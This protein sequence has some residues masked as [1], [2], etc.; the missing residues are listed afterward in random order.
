MADPVSWKVVEKGWKVVA[1]DGEELGS[2][3][4]V[5]GDANA[6]I[7]N[8][9]NVSPGV[10]RHS[11][12]VPAERVAAIWEGR[13]ELDLDAGAFERLAE[14]EPAPP[15]AEIRADTTDLPGPGGAPA[16]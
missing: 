15:S 4:D 13:V 16:G 5:V 11:R 6:D 14:A 12:Y 3:H 10:L 1:A 2:V 9:L 8:G 7:F